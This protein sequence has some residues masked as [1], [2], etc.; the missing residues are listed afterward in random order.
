ML[1]LAV[2]AMTMTAANAQKGSFLLAGSVGYEKSGA[3]DSDTKTYTFNPKVG[4]QITDHVT[5]GAESLLSRIDEEATD[6]QSNEYK[7]GGFVRYAQPLGGPFSIYG[8]LGSGYQRK[9]EETHDINDKYTTADGFYIGFTPALS[10][11]FHAGLALNV[12][13]GG[14]GYNQYDYDDIDVK[15][16]GFNIDL[17]KSISVGISKNFR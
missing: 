6:T 7:I 1:M 5:L 11:D 2:A 13:I 15:E 9:Q 8:D 10:V 3:E 14:I 4:Y 16:S 17:G 12:S